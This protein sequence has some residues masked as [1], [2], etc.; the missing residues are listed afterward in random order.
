MLTILFLIALFIFLILVMC[1]NDKSKVW[2]ALVIADIIFIFGTIIPIVFLI[3]KSDNS[4]F[5]KITTTTKTD[6]VK[7]VAM[8]NQDEV[9][10]SFLLGCGS[11]EGKQYYVFYESTEQ[12]I[13]QKKISTDGVIIRYTKSS[14][15]YDVVTTKKHRKCKSKVLDVLA[16]NLLSD[17]YV[18]EDS[19]SG[20]MKRIFYVPKGSI[21]ENYDLN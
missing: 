11:L 10:G 6:S 8:K 7:I 15:H 5:V 18:F 4:D 3:S 2:K 20:A 1:M 17:H 12:G 14:A 9:S 13:T 19:N 21:K 16:G